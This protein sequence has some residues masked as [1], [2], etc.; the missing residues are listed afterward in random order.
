MAVQQNFRSAFNGFNREDVVH[1]IEYLNSK[2]T[3][4]LNQLKSEIEYLQGRV[5][6]E[7][8][9]YLESEETIA[10]QAAQIQELQEQNQALAEELEAL[11]TAPAQPEA[12]PLDEETDAPAEELTV[13]PENITAEQDDLAAQIEA[14]TAERDDLAAQLE[15]AAAEQ[16]ALNA[17]LENIQE[18]LNFVTDE[19]NDMALELDEILQQQ[20]VQKSHM[21]EELAAYRRAERAERLAQERA[22]KMYTQASSVIA[23][24]TVKVDEASAQID[25]MSETVLAQLELLK[26]AISGS[27]ASLKDAAAT[28]YAIQPETEE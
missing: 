1:Y 5:A 4:E 23:D 15:A 2:H 3:A 18:Q 19:R 17:K 8:N 22:H 7:G 26:M 13:Q 6:L 24:A 9:D 12:Q 16:E 27:T 10:Q 28:M 21:E 11:R 25:E 20:S 14:V